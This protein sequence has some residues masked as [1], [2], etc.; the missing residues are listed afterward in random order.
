MPGQN[1]IEAHVKE[2]SKGFE[3]T[4][5]CVVRR[6]II[7][8]IRIFEAFRCEERP[9]LPSLIICKSEISNLTRKFEYNTTYEI[10]QWK[11]I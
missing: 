10:C 8:K 4:A 9:I 6:E 1:L 11:N 5:N 2:N 3:Q 7:R